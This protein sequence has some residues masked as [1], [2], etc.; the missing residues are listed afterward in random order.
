M[1]GLRVWVQR[2]GI[3][4]CAAAEGKWRPQ[5]SGARV[6]AAN[7][8]DEVDSGWAGGAVFSSGAL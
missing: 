7:E 1:P 2:T 6:N 8:G 4:M 3:G 5:L